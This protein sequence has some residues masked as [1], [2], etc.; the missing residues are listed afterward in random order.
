MLKNVLSEHYPEKSKI[1]K[2]T[3]D[4][5]ETDMI[6]HNTNEIVQKKIDYF[7]E[8][9]KHKDDN[10]LYETYMNTQYNTQHDFVDKFKDSGIDDILKK[11]ENWKKKI[12][13][14]ITSMI[15]EFVEETLNQNSFFYRNMYQYIDIILI[16]ILISMV[17]VIFQFALSGYMLYK[18][19]YL[20]KFVK[21]YYDEKY[22]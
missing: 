1:I 12:F 18:I 17:L 15:K 5:N 21:D 2:Q 14:M 16:I 13:S 22:I 9:I 10:N 6:R 19:N 11:I 8:Y 7:E 20:H 4:E 3:I